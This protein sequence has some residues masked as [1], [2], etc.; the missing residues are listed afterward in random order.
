VSV[1]KVLMLLWLNDKILKHGWLHF[2]YSENV[3][4]WCKKV[5]ISRDMTLFKSNHAILHHKTLFITK[6]VKKKFRGKVNFPRV[7]KKSCAKTSSKISSFCHKLFAK[8]KTGFRK[9]ICEKNKCIN[10]RP[11]PTRDTRGFSAQCTS[12]WYIQA[13]TWATNK[14]CPPS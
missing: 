4:G 1:W 9:K 2:Y 12:C 10:F 3:A 5:F 11:N 6:I 8:T 14:C 13:A 7:F